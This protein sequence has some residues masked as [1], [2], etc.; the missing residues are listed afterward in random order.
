[1][2]NIKGGG[3]RYGLT[4]GLNHMLAFYVWI[5]LCDGVPRHALTTAAATALTLNSARRFST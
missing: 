3:T 5:D 1:M 2:T 4:P